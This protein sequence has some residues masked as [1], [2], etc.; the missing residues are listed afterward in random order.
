MRFNAIRR[1]LVL[2]VLVCILL[3]LSPT[4]AQPASGGTRLEMPDPA[5]VV[6]LTFDDG[7]RTDTTAALLDGLALR[8]VPATFF[9]VGECI[10]GNESLILRMA[11]DGHQVGIHTYDHVQVTELTKDDFNSQVNRTR[12]LLTGLLGEG[13]FW[14]RPP[15]GIVDESVEQ[16]A[17]CPLILWSVDPEDW[18]DQNTDHI[19]RSVLSQTEDGDIILLHDIYPT[20]VDAALQIVDKLLEDGYLFVTVEQLMKLRGVEPVSGELYR[21]LPPKA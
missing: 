2:G 13:T 7:P 10:P 5:P 21:S 1:V 17:D 16:W 19:V 18:D 15:Y 20:S 8:E 3:V 9:L 11:Q 12:A 6:A 14:L 4:P